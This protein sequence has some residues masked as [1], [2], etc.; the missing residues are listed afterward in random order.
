MDKYLV[1]VADMLE[2][3]SVDLT[4]EFIQF[5]SWDSLTL[6]SII[7]GI[8]SLYGVIVSSDE[9]LEARTIG[10]LFCTLEKKLK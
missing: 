9:I 7:A 6:L 5:E 4:D 3:E 1:M 2:V 8:Q 10:E